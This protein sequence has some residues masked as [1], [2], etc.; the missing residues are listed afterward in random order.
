MIISVVDMILELEEV[1]ITIVGMEL[2]QAKM[3][4]REVNMLLELVK[5]IT[6]VVA[7]ELEQE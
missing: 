5:I 4:I 2:E 7:I 6:V 3:M 1:M